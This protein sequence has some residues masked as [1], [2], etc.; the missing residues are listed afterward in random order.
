[1]KY[2][3]ISKTR[4]GITQVVDK[5]S[6]TPVHA[7]MGGWELVTNKE[8]GKRCILA[9]EQ[10]AQSAVPQEVHKVVLVGKGATVLP[11][12]KAISF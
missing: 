7:A 2:I 8:C 10:A 4:G 11:K 9:A 3:R 12:P 1:M 6:F 5:A